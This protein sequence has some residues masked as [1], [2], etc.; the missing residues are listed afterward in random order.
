MPSITTSP[1]APFTLQQIGT[2]TCRFPSGAAI[3]TATDAAVDPYIRTRISKDFQ[4]DCIQ[5]W[6]QEKG[7]YPGLVLLHEWWGLNSQ[8]KD[9]GARL[10]CEGY[11]VIIPNLYGRLGGMVT[12]NAEV[13]E[14]LM[15]KLSEP[16]V[17]QDI[18]SCCEFMNTRD[19]G[20]RNVHGIVG[21]GMGGTFA[22]RFAAQRKR[23]RAAVSFYGRIPDPQ[24][25]VKDLYCPVLYHHAGRDPWVSGEDVTRL[26]S[27]AKE[28][29]KRVEIRTYPDAEHAFCNELRPG[30]YRADA[31]AEA[32][33][34]TASF[35]KTCFQGT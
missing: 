15:N 30:S 3:P 23:L 25:M 14:A 13:A 26:A 9:L 16:L 1:T 31:A 35:L 21:F 33:N 27:L 6:P 28:H 34:A 20:K 22:L 17:L 19:Y 24:T 5:F 10:A 4:V 8:I 7:S 29:Q 32:W 12:A 11:N 2:G 18:N